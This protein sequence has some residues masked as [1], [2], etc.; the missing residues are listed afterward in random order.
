MGKDLDAAFD[1]VERFDTNARAI[2]M[3][4]MT[5]RSDKIEEKREALQQ[6]VKV[7]E[8]EHKV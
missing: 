3:A 8:Q 2:L 6:I 5:G 1:A 4:R 7:H